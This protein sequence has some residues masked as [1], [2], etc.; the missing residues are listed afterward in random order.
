MNVSYLIGTI[1][2]RH[3]CRR[4]SSGHDVTRRRKD[5]VSL[6]GALLEA[7]VFFVGVR[8][9]CSDFEDTAIG[10]FSPTPGSQGFLGDDLMK[11]R[12]RV[13]PEELVVV[14]QTVLACSVRR[15]EMSVQFGELYHGIFVETRCL[16]TRHL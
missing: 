15:R 9:F 8:K 11:H 4:C 16:E 6:A 10:I 1:H 14:A 13:E 5:L 3:P 7:G 2:P 12:V